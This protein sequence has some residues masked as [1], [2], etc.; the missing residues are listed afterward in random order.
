VDAIGD[1]LE[2]VFEKLP[3]GFT[4][5]L[6]H[7]LGDSELACPVNADEEIELSLASLHLSDVDVEEADRV[8]L[9]LLPRRLVACD[10]RQARD[11]MPLQAPM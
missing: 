1:G 9:E 4:I 10:V 11:A 8:A 2:Q 6:V 3:C 7:E 5:C